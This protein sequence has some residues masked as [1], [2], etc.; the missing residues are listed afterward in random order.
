LATKFY[1]RS[2]S[3]GVGGT[4]PSAEQSTLAVTSGCNFEGSQ[5]TNRTLDT[6]VG[7]AQTTLAFTGNMATSARNYY[8]SRWVSPVIYDTSVSAQTWTY[9]FAARETST[10]CNFPCSGNNGAVYVCA[11]VWKPSNGT[12]YGNILDGNSAATVDEG[13][14]NATVGHVVS[15][16][17]SAVS[18]LTPGDA[19]I[20]F[21][22]WFQITSG[23]TTSQTLTFYYD[24][25][26]DPTENASGLTNVASYI[27]TP[28]NLTFTPP[29]PAVVSTTPADNELDVLI[30]STIVI[31]FD[32]D[33][34]ASTITTSN[35]TVKDSGNNTIAGSW[36]LSAG[37]TVATFTPSS[38]L[39]NN[40]TITVT[41]TTAVQ[42][43]SGTAIASQYVFDF[44]TQATQPTGN[45]TILQTS[46]YD[47]QATTANQTQYIPSGGRCQI[48]SVESEAQVTFR[49][50]GSIDRFFI[51]IIANS[52]AADSKIRTRKNGNNGRCEV[53]IGS[54]ATGIFEDTAHYD[55]VSAGDELCYQSVPGAATGTY[56]LTV[57]GVN[58]KSTTDT[59]TRC[60]AVSS[61]A[62]TTQGT[63]YKLLMGEVGTNTTE[64]NAQTRIKK[65]GTAKNLFCNIS[66]NARTTDTTIRLRK[67]SADS[68][69]VIV[70]GSGAIGFFED[71]THTESIAVDDDIAFSIATG[72]G[73]ESLT[74]KSIAVSYITTDGSGLAS[75]GRSSGFSIN[76]SLTNYFNIS[77]FFGGGVTTESNAHRTVREAYTFSNLNINVTANTI[78]A[79]SVLTFRKN[80]TDGNQIITIGSGATG[81]LVDTTHTDVT[82]A[83]DEVDYQLITGGAGTSINIRQMASWSATAAGQ[84]IERA[85]ATETITISDTGTPI[86]RLAAKIRAP[87]TETIT[88][89]SG[90]LARLAA[91]MRPLATQT[92]TASESIAKIRGRNP[93]LAAQTVTISET[94]SRIKSALRPLTT[95]TITVG[96]GTLT[97]LAAKMRALA[98]QTVTITEDL[99]RTVSAA[100]QIVRTITQ[101]VDISESIARLK[102]ST[103]TISQTVTIDETLARIKGAMRLLATE[104]V[105]ISESLAR[106]KG[107]VKA[108]A[109]ETVTI[110]AETLT[111]IKGA[112]RTLSTQTVTLTEDITRLA[113]KI[114]TVSQSVTISEQLERTIEGA[115][116]VVRSITETVEI[117]GVIARQCA[118]WRRIPRPPW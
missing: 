76:I 48:V 19:V 118:K 46:K 22:A 88:I 95:E 92:V 4:L 87:S 116:E 65:A 101:T 17:G 42:N 97:R 50:A 82:A 29:N 86:A 103:R 60:I 21:E 12:K 113:A 47:G 20:V 114:R 35:I 93:T 66:A 34:L 96:A 36:A 90:T 108:L 33:M 111:R 1:L 10:S 7:S 25:A 91:K 84:A 55:I 14:A 44:T 79:D 15:F 70:V 67:N 110:G 24:G 85:L 106:I 69:L 112:I 61:V 81:R 26:T 49:E 38:N 40:E 89:G 52:V 62:I 73:T 53:T 11:Y 18:S 23:V 13:S 74:L 45:P 72:T 6:N 104:T 30:D 80:N 98:T 16:T 117:V 100:Q 78:T 39:A 31:T 3:S 107:A 54:N 37:D 75:A 8:V 32:Q 105:T 63:W 27:S 83:G 58:Y 28:Q 2:G 64:N 9:A 59:V 5:T 68:A 102:A 41:V 115:N 71:I 56:T 77:G 109:T 43:E 51:N 94:L 57:L 99:Q